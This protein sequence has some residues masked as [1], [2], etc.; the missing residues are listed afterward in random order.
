MEASGFPPYY[1]SDNEKQEYIDIVSNHEGVKL[2]K[3]DIKYNVGRRTV[4]NL[5]LEKIITKSKFDS[6]IIYYRS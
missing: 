3:C 4:E 6:T 2:N 5:C 1:K